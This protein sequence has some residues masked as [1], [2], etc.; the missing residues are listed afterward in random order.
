MRG[1][2]VEVQR[3]AAWHIPMYTPWGWV[4]GGG[5][6]GFLYTETSV[7]EPLNRHSKILVK[8]CYY[9]GLTCV[10]LFVHK[11]IY[12]NT[13]FT[14]MASVEYNIYKLYAEKSANLS[15]LKCA[16]YF[17]RINQSYS[18]CRV[19]IVQVICGSLHN[20]SMFCTVHI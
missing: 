8:H 5:R 12:H 2:E 20:D 10:C 15:M 16:N 17:R 6:G 9:G 13:Y 19:C 18:N 3:A 7:Y 1:E 14:I 11:Y 4:E